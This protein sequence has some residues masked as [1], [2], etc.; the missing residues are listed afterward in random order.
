MKSEVGC[1]ACQICTTQ[2]LIWPRAFI[3]VPSV[4]IVFCHIKTNAWHGVESK[5]M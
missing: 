4:P 1:T 5:G 2:E 3:I